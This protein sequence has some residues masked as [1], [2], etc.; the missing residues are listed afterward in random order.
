MD[1]PDAVQRMPLPGLLTSLP[2]AQ[3]VHPRVFLGPLPAAFNLAFL[4]T[5][6]ITH[7]V[8]LAAG[9]LAHHIVATLKR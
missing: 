1:V 3:E 4:S 6:G 8:N 9:E 5:R 7:I 2:I